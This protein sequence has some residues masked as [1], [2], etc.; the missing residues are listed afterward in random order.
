MRRILWVV[1]RGVYRTEHPEWVEPVS[2]SQDR[3]GKCHGVRRGRSAWLGTGRALEDC[4]SC[5]V[6]FCGQGGPT[7]RAADYQGRLGSEAAVTLGS[8]PCRLSPQQRSN[9]RGTGPSEKCHK[10][11]SARK[12][13]LAR[14]LVQNENRFPTDSGTSLLSPKAFASA[15]MARQP[16]QW[17]AAIKERSTLP[18][19]STVSGII[20]SFVPER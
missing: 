9:P 3:N 11:K 20:R 1:P 14:P 5:V 10:R 15:V 2:L 4:R 13:V 12:S 16:V 8:A 19:A 6:T 17:P 18:I 7:A